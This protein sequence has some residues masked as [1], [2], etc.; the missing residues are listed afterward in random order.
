[1]WNKTVI[2]ASLVVASTAALAGCAG[3]EPTAVA[4]DTVT[5]TTTKTVT[6]DPGR[7][8]THTPR[9]SDPTQPS[10]APTT[11]PSA[12]TSQSKLATFNTSQRYRYEDGLEVSIPHAMLY[13]PSQYA[14]GTNPG[15]KAVK[16]TVEVTNDSGKVF[17]PSLLT[18]TASYG[19][20]GEQADQI[21]GDKVGM[22]FTTSVPPGRTASADFAFSVPKSGLGNLIVEVSPD[23]SHDNA[24]FEGKVTPTHP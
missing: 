18:V 19:K 14:A 6:P 4:P 24:L 21:Y 23:F 8:P 20:K 16:F 1:M 22:G 11:T 10:E 13:R 5:V 3:S 12:S 15:D 7:G 9:S 2:A 17:D